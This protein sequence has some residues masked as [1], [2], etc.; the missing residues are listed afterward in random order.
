MA[1][2]DPYA[3]LPRLYDL[4]HAAFDDDLPLYGN[5]AEAVG[6]P[7]LELGCGTGRVLVP[8]A[9]AGF[10]VTGLDR[11]GPMLDAARAASAAAGVAAR[12]TLHEGAMSEADRA[13]GGPFGLVLAPLDALLHA[14]DAAAQRATL[15]AARR[16]MDPR[17]QLVID[18][19]NPTPDALAALERGVVH[20]GS[21]EMPD[22]TRV[23]KFGARRVHPASQLISTEL[24]Y[25]LA[26][27]DGALRRV[28][29]SYDLRY[30]HRAEL[31]LMLELA[32]FVEWEV[33]GG[34]ELEPFEDGSDRLVVTAEVTRSR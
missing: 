27:P 34:Y 20:E 30:L 2:H 23:D 12:V 11:S 22:G 16:A 1:A 29:T 24:W 28:R 10:R 5:I 32:G 18:V 33:Y 19:V 15:E 3:A 31:E 13:P 4:Q 21:W 7:I 26:A 6:D 17:G 9:E 25:D 14:G 8:L